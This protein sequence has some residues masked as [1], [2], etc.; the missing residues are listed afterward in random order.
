ML[1]CD[2]SRI[3]QWDMQFSPAFDPNLSSHMLM[4]SLMKK[5]CLHGECGKVRVVSALMNWCVCVCM[6]ACTCY[7]RG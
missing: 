2:E 3:K 5:I 1:Q 6:C 4:N 7:I